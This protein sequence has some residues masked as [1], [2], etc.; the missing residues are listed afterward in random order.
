MSLPKNVI[1]MQAQFEAVG[2]DPPNGTMTIDTKAIGAVIEC[3][4]IRAARLYELI[5]NA[6]MNSKQC[7][8][9]SHPLNWSKVVMKEAKEK[10]I[11]P[12]RMIEP[13]ENLLIGTDE[14]LKQL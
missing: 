10:N 8:G 4:M 2:I 11:C 1:D 13:E 14:W 9:H 12:A 7:N 5:C 3:P 6:N